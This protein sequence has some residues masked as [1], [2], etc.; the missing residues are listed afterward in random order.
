MLQTM[1]WR[2]RKRG[3]SRTRKA[4]M[5]AKGRATRMMR[6]KVWRFVVVVVVVV[7]VCLSFLLGSELS[8]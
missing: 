6:R 8:F 5:L 2:G 3:T 1:L 4:S 7:R